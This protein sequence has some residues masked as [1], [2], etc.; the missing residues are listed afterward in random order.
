MR[1]VAMQGFGSKDFLN[2]RD[3]IREVE[4]FRHFES[5]WGFVNLHLPL[6]L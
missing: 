4:K 5:A 1:N 3:G 6:S 2:V